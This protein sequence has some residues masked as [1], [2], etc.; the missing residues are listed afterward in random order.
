MS[1][2][3]GPG[4]EDAGDGHRELPHVHGWWK[5]GSFLCWGGI[6]ER[7]RGHLQRG[8]WGRAWKSTLRLRVLLQSCWGLHTSS[9]ISK[10]L[11]SGGGDT[12][13]SCCC[14]PRDTTKMCQESSCGTISIVAGAGK[15]PRIG[16]GSG[17]AS[18]AGEKEPTNATRDREIL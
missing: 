9:C 13:P 18:T 5:M 3:W 14:F 6:N 12:K 8:L 10:L 2:W 1:P 11:Q 7:W 17:C 16:L 4:C 15:G